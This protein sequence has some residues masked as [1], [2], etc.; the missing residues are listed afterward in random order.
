MND[1]P[2]AGAYIVERLPVQDAPLLPGILL[3]LAVPESG[4]W[5]LAGDDRPPY[6]AWIWPGGLALAQHVAAQPTQLA[7]KRVLDLGTGSGIV[8]IA[9]ARAGAGV[10]A[11]D[12]DP[13][14][15]TAERLN[16]ALNGVEIETCL[17]DLLDGLPPQVDHVLVG[18]LFCEQELA[19]RVL[20]FLE[21]C[22]AAGLDVLVGDIGRDDLPRSQLVEIAA[23][24]VS[25]FGEGGTHRTASVYRL[26]T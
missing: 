25:E 18:D 2:D 9:A 23:Y 6:W 12:V 11:S 20:P 10:I 16:A 1:V 4:V 26:K 14:A 13:N 21:R 8:A 19:A 15:L 22:S 3:R 7:G 5:R 17:A 24:P